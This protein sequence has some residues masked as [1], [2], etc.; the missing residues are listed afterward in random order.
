M[1]WLFGRLI[2]L[3]ARRIVKAVDDG[4]DS[5]LSVR[6]KRGQT[7]AQLLR[8]VGRVVILLIAGLLS[9]DIFFDIGPLLAGAGIIGLA[10]SFGAQ[11]LVKDIISGFFILFEN[12]F[13]VGDVIETAGKSGTVERMTLR[14]VMLRDLRG[15]AAHHSERA[16]DRG[17]QPDPGLG[18]RRGRSGR[19]LRGRRRSRARGLPRRGGR[20]RQGPGLAAPARRGARGARRRKPRRQRGHDP[21]HAAHVTGRTM[22]RGARVPPP[23]QEPARQG[24]HRHSLSAAHGPRAA[25]G[26][27]AVD[28]APTLQH[29]DPQRSS[30]FAPVVPGRV[31][32]YTC[33]PTVWNYAHIGNFR[34]FVFEDLLRRWLKASRARGVPDHEPHRRGRPHHRRGREAGGA[35]PRVHRR[36]SRTPSYEDREFLRIQ[37]AEAYPRA[38]DFIAPMVRLVEG[39]LAKRRRVPRATTARSTSRSSGFPPTAGCR[40]LDRRELKAGASARVASDEYAKEDARDFALWKAAKPEDEAVGAAWDAPFGRGRPGL[41]PRVL[42]DGARA[43]RPEVRRR[44]ARHPRRRRGPDLPAPRGRDRAVLR[45]H[46]RSRISRGSGCT[47]S[48]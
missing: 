33:G 14:V 6:E 45:L 4:D 17:E 42:G 11:S 43:D 30:R 41:A 48:S 34:T 26:G 21:H 22:G 39:L 12:Q 28:D 5:H 16:D 10:I 18:P 1:A 19:G 8:S 23:D 13:A 7:I 29:H 3:I 9:L 44:R 20:V 31:T 35:D 25:A 37:D 46:R 38:T 32:L 15:R 36:P 2:R 40:Q 24:R 47:A 27:R